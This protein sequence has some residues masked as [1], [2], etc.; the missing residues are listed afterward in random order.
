MT[1]TAVL[2]GLLSALVSLPQSLL[3]AQELQLERVR[4]LDLS[5]TAPDLDSEV[6]AVFEHAGFNPPTEDQLRV[7]R[8]KE[9]TVRNLS[10][11]SSTVKAGK[12]AVQNPTNAAYEQA[13]A[14]RLN[15]LRQSTGNSDIFAM[16]FMVFKESIVEQNEDKRFWLTKLQMMNT[17]AEALRDYLKYLNEKMSQLEEAKAKQDDEDADK[18]GPEK[19]RVDLKVFDL[20]ADDRGA[21]TGCDSI[22]CVTARARWVTADQLRNEIRKVEADRETV[23]NLRQMAATQFENANKISGQYINMLAS[24]LKT[25]KD[26]KAGVNRNMR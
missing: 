10:A 7:I 6:A 17:I 20:G 22:P 1:R 9:T 15:A 24:I 19:V 13:F 12:L 5:A 26:M 25:M 14:R 16:L 11:F 18:R 3:I 2:V 8:G 21:I 23:R 4:S